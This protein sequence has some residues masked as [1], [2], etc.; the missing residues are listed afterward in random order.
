VNEV[1]L[2]DN[3]AEVIPTQTKAEEPS[4]LLQMAHNIRKNLDQTKQDIHD[5]IYNGLLSPRESQELADASIMT[6]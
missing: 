4:L 3:L 6:E 5:I 2:V 1:I